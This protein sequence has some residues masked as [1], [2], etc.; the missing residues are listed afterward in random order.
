MCQISN[1]GAATF[2]FYC[3]HSAELN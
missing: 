2:Q 3:V 1:K